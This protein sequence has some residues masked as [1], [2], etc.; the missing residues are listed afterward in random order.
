[1]AKFDIIS[2]DG[3][4]KRYSG[5][6]RYNGTYLK[7][8]YVEFAEISSHEPILWE[9]G[10][11]VD[12]ERTGMRYYLYSIP[13]ETKNAR[14]DS[15]GRAFVYSNVQFF[16]AT[17]DLEIALFRDIV[18]ED[19]NVHFST[20][21]DVVTFENVEGISRRIS[22]CLN[23]MYPDK[24][25]VRIADFDEVE[26]AEI[27]ERITAS[28][29]FA[30]SGGT[31]L[32]ALTKI[33]EL[34]GDLGWIHS[35]E[36]GKEII[37]IGYANKRI[38]E[39][40]SDAYLYGKSKGLTSIKK[41]LT[42]KGEFA[43]RLYIYGSE[44]NLPSRYYNDKNIIN[45]ESVDIRNL[46]IPVGS[47]GLT[48]ELPDA[49]K[50]YIENKDAVEKYGVIPK[51]HYFDSEESGADVY[52]TIEKMTVGKV[53]D[54]LI[55]LGETD[56]YPNETIYLDAEERVDEI[57][58]ASN[59]DDNG[60]MNKDGKSYDE[61]RAIEISQTTVTTNIPKESTSATLNSSLLAFGE[62]ETKEGKI[63]FRTGSEIEGYLVDDG[64][65]SAATVIVELADDLTKQVQYSQRTEIELEDA[66]DGKRMFTLPRIMSTSME[67]SDGI[68]AYVSIKINVQFASQIE[69]A[70][71]CEYNINSGS[72]SIEAK[73]KL[74]KEFEVSLKQIGFDI[75]Q[76]AS[77]GEGK[78]LLMKSG[79][80]EGRTFKISE[81]VYKADT[82][83]WS[84]TCIRQ[85][86]D[87]LKMFFPNK[88]YTILAGDRI[89][90]LDIS[91]PD[92][93]VAVAEDTLLSEG[94][95]LLER[96]SKYQYNFE[97]SIDS[98]VMAQSE[99]V[100]RE[101]MYMEIQDEDIISSGV[102]YMLIDSL[103]IYEDESNI[104]TYKVTLREK[105]KVTYKGTPSATAQ[106]STKS[107][108]DISEESINLSDYATKEFVKNTIANNESGLF[109]YD[110]DAGMIKAKYGLYS[111]GQLT[112][113]GKGTSPGGASSTLEGLKD[114]SLT[115]LSDGQSLVWDSEKKAWVNKKVSGGGGDASLE[116]D[117]TAEVAVG[118]IS[119]SSTLNEGMTFTEFVQLMFSQD[120]KK[121]PPTVTLEGVPNYD[122]EVGA[123]VVLNL[124]S[125]YKDGYFTNTKDGK[126]QAGCEAGAATFYLD[127]EAIEVPYTL[128]TDSAKVYAVSVRQPYGDST[129]EVINKAGQTV[130]DSI[131]AGTATAQRS[132]TVGYRAFWG[133]MTDNEAENL[134]SDLVRG[135]EHQDTIINPSQSV[136][137][138]LN[139]ENEIPAGEDLIIAIPEGYALQSVIDKTT[140]Q[141]IKFEDPTTLAVE[142]GSASQNY[143]VY[144]YD[145]YNEDA[146]MYITR[147]TIEKEA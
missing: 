103:N 30:L 59:P 111:L 19:N 51:V 46:M 133:Y 70:F 113:G 112:A 129:A 63:T 147:I 10:D 61:I 122:I 84:L 42:N 27:L 135:L 104:P 120:I 35:Q 107:A 52:P 110:E 83:S 71:D 93:Y 62:F 45:A 72:C 15:H 39:N 89:A 123:S 94:K 132:F 23:D 115:T 134:T 7:P 4:S 144:R 92:L 77:L 78:T 102:E 47:W 91:M 82:D 117:V 137:T 88:D 100:L 74:P 138:L 28:K 105:K 57:L 79:M 50:A 37:T 55:S 26:D 34:W 68:T 53:R 40:T 98:I 18:S 16:A 125:L 56:Y 99:R 108:Q 96:A 54:A 41:N 130:E 121:Y 90:V 131:S 66:I 75:S 17:K 95:K 43:T 36:G 114:V 124:T 119:K 25:E 48:D 6:L 24:W 67:R 109:E 86:D 118:Y 13:P 146:A 22:A 14:K 11:Y 85:Q 3:E 128:A 97:P 142:C 20:S 116:A 139:E 44:R 58:S 21:P 12:Y 127:N 5:K 29:D 8:S 60:E 9:V 81:C 141:P 38:E 2:K 1:M 69:E 126:T 106:T 143:K 73:G 76:R 136:I 33:Y 32:D 145:N 64:K 101:G 80:C 49:R 140:S 31:C 65:I 87:T